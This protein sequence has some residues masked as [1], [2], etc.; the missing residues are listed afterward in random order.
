MN[1]ALVCV[2]LQE[3]AQEFFVP[4]RRF[5]LAVHTWRFLRASP[6]HTRFNKVP[7]IS[8]VI[9]LEYEFTN[10]FSNLQDLEILLLPV[11]DVIESV[12]FVVGLPRL[13]K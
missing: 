4:F 3:F 8:V 12:F 9:F 11:I 1:I 10:G 2:Y 6:L 7:F 13:L 5:G